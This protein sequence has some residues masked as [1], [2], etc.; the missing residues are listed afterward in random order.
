MRE[1]LGFRGRSA[2]LSEIFASLDSDDSGQVGF[3][4]LYASLRAL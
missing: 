1:K 2:V 3:D 4:E